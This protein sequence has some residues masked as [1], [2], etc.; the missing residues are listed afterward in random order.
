[1]QC[2]I[3]AYWFPICLT[4]SQYGDVSGLPDPF[5]GDGVDGGQVKTQQN[6]QHHP[7][8]HMTFEESLGESGYSTPNS[9]NRRIIR[10]IIV[11]FQFCH[12]KA[13]ICDP[14]LKIL[15]W[16]LSSP[17]ASMHTVRKSTIFF[18]IWF[19]RFSK[20]KS[21]QILGISCWFCQLLLHFLGFFLSEVKPNFGDQL[22][23]LSAVAPIFGIFS[24]V[25]SIQILG[26]SCR[27]FQLLFHFLGIFF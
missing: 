7:M 21:I 4:D 8:Q 16:P 22:S 13:A 11:W 2:K 17:L 18:L 20:V 25:N 19:N 23:I 27:F 26:I 6:S 5:H 1:M 9:R 12:K 24:K 10:E 14:V 3:I 15:V